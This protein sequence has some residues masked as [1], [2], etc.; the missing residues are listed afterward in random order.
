MGSSS[1]TAHGSDGW[2]SDVVPPHSASAVGHGQSGSHL[3]RKRVEAGV[4]GD[5]PMLGGRD[6]DTE[7][8]RMGWG[9]D[10]RHAHC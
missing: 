3:I 10:M 9:R 1:K 7:D 6:S 5:N 4:D 8:N 2:S